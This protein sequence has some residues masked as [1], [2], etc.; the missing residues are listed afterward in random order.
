MSAIVTVDPT[1]KAM[2]SLGGKCGLMCK[3][4]YITVSQFDFRPRLHVDQ[5]IQALKTEVRPFDAI[6]ISG[7]V[8]P[9]IREREFLAL[10]E[11]AVL[12]F[13]D[14]HLMFTTRLIPSEPG[15][16]RIVAVARA[17]ASRARLLAPGVSLMT[18]TYPNTIENPN[19]VP[20]TLDRIAFASRMSKAGIP[21][22]AALRPTMPFSVVPK[23]EVRAL[24]RMAA[25]A[26]ACILGEA[27]ILDTGDELS[28]RF[29]LPSVRNEQAERMTFLDQPSL[30]VKRR[31]ELEIA[32]TATQSRENGRP[33]F[34]R[35][36]SAMRYLETVWDYS[37]GRPGAH[38]L[39]AA[40][41][42]DH[43]NP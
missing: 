20:P 15:F 16:D 12:Q 42:Y 19:A 25:P 1:R 22:L 27:F 23:E 28:A 39:Y 34:L 2:V 3:H 5:V 33:Y 36:M 14:V 30:W 6:C 8:D 17:L 11:E 35:S 41:A 37:T 32:Y 10:L 38:D 4:C 7:D 21:V 31:L 26:A 9:L 13:P 29:S 24:V 18:A 43:D 40:G